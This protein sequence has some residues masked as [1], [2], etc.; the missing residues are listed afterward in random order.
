MGTPKSFKDDKPLTTGLPSTSSRDRSS[1]THRSSLCLIFPSGLKTRPQGLKRTSP[2]CTLKGVQ[3]RET[4]LESSRPNPISP[5]P[6][7]RFTHSVTPPPPQQE[8]G[9]LRSGRPQSP[10]GLGAL[11]FRRRVETGPELLGPGIF[12][13]PSP[14]PS[15]PLPRDL[16]TQ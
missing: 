10:G 2:R 13:C 16:P 5:R 3:T 4:S 9:L 11:H 12:L 14:P 8:F 1:L 7:P 15:T 6:V